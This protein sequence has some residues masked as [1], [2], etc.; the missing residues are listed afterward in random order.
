MNLLCFVL[1][2]TLQYVV[3]IFLEGNMFKYL[4]EV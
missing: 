1:L 3:S 4:K 2:E